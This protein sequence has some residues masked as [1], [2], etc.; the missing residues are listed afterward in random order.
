MDSSESITKLMTALGAAQC[1]MGA[2]VRDHEAK[3]AGQKAQYSYTY[4][5]LAAC[6]EV[7]RQPLMDQGLAVVQSAEYLGESK[8]AKIETRMVH[9]S[10][11]WIK[12]IVIMPVGVGNNPAQAIGITITYA[13]RYAYMAMVGLAPEDPDA[14]GLSTPPSGNGAKT[15][16]PKTTPDPGAERCEVR[17]RIVDKITASVKRVEDRLWPDG[18]LADVKDRIIKTKNHD[19]PKQEYEA[20]RAILAEVAA[21]GR[22]VSAVDTAEQWVTFAEAEKLVKSADLGV[23]ETAFYLDSLEGVKDDPDELLAAYREIEAAISKQKDLPLDE[24]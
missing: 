20:L 5:D 23:Q 3:V 1:A 4:A 6:H 11:E 13:R 17:Q 2:L 19:T 10:G 21:K 22:E 8:A 15:T 24:K 14:A 18:Y 16:V 9:S 12:S 7:S